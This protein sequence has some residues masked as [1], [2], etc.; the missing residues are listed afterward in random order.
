MKTFILILLLRLKA[1]ATVLWAPTVV[2]AATY[3]RHSGDHNTAVRDDPRS[4]GAMRGFGV[5]S[6]CCIAALAWD[7]YQ[8]ASI[9]ASPPEC[10]RGEG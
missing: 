5:G 2:V 3:W 7:V 8:R 9:T 10:G 1:A 4:Q 6:M